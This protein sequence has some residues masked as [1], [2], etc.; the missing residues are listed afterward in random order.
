MTSTLQLPNGFLAHDDEGAGSPVVLLH[1]GN[2]DR[3]MWSP[4]LTPLAGR[5]RVVGY[6]AQAHGESST[7]RGRLAHHEDLLALVDALGL[8]RPVLVGCSL[9]ARTAV[10]A[11]LTRPDRFAALVLVSPGVSGMTFTDPHYLREQEA[12]DAAIAAG[13]LAAMVEGLLRQ[14]VD[15]PRRRPDEVAPEVREAC[16]CMCLHTLATH[17]AG[18][19]TWTVDE[20]DAVHR[21]GELRVPL[22]V[23]TGALDG[24]DVHRV[25][26][27]LAALPQ[28]RHVEVPDAGHLVPLE[29]PEAVLELVLGAAA[30]L[31]A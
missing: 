21:L 12:V 26:G 9:G 1:A 6:D 20:L 25:A 22:H 3:R 8:D 4:V 2:L 16:R 10:D 30:T 5:H 31:V 24:G 19:M 11:A 28:A 29:A 18:G 27:A 15:G 23:V 17:Y 14:W 13:D 7:P